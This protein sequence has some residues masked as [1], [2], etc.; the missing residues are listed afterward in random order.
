MRGKWTAGVGVGAIIGRRPVTAPRADYRA[1]S[2]RGAADSIST[3]ALFVRP[4]WTLVARPARTLADI[5]VFRRG[6]DC[7]A[8][9]AEIRFLGDLESLETVVGQDRVD[10][11]P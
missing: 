9:P 8:I 6:I 3:A 5:S 11:S 7:V 1:V 10:Q 4:P 2:K